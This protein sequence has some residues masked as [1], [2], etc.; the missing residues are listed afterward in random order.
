MRSLHSLF[1]T[2]V[3]AAS[4]LV[5]YPHDRCR[6]EAV[7]DAPFAQEYHEPQVL[8]DDPR[9][10]DVRSVAVDRSGK[11]WAATAAGVYR[12]SGDQEWS[13]MSPEGP[14]YAVASSPSHTVWAGTW[15]GIYHGRE[16]LTR[17]AGV[18]APIS[19][20]T[21]TGNRVYCF[22]PRGNWLI[23]TEG[24]TPFRVTPI[25]I[26][27]SKS[28]RAASIGPA[29]KLWLATQ[30]GIYRWDATRRSG[31]YWNRE[32]LP[33]ADVRDLLFAD[34]GRLWVGGLG[35]L[36]VFR[37]SSVDPSR[38]ADS[39]PSVD[40]RA[41]ASDPNGPI[42]VATSAGVSRLD[43]DGWSVRHSRRWLLSD[44]VRDIVCD[45]QGTAWIATSQGVSAI[46]RRQLTLAEKAQHFDRICQTR[47]VR[48]PGLVEK[49][50]LKTPG[51][52]TTW[53]P[54]DDD[55]DGQYTSMYLAME[56]FRYAATHDPVAKA[57][58]KRAF[59]ALR[60][61]QTVTQ[62]SGFVARTVIPSSW[63]RMHD[64]NQ[65][66][67]AQ[68]QAERM[69]GDPRDKYVPVRW[70]RSAD[71]Q[72]LWKGD[73]SSD[74]ITGHYYGYLMYYDL[75][76]DEAERRHVAQHVRKVTDYIIANGYVLQGMDGKPT[77]WGV[78]SPERLNHDPDWEMDRSTNSVELLSYL[79]AAYHMTG[80]AKYQQHYLL[81][82]REHGYAENARQ[83]KTMDPAWRTH[84]DDEL[85][86]LA[87]PALLL[88][89]TDPALRKIYRE[90]LD[91]WYAA[92]SVD[93]GPFFHLTYASLTGQ[94]VGSEETLRF[95]R[96]TPLDLVRWRVDNS[97][98]EDVQVTHF[99]EL[100]RDQTSRLLPID[101]ICFTRWD[102]NP[103]DTV[104][105]DGGHTESD[106]VF[107][108]LP[109]WMARYYDFLAGPH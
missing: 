29:G 42:W 41:V 62:T 78:W 40:I 59:E 97:H 82:I 35:G 96:D 76:A 67:T 72:W 44:D 80:D 13:L 50:H 45:D 101:E 73:T 52:L 30:M 19:V 4:L 34:D 89:E 20:I 90:S 88:K 38:S 86:A 74:E 93:R 51:D 75:V 68:Q 9:A 46:K 64:P 84:I 83:S 39:L 56:S 71:G 43:A 3:A 17:M 2:S 26:A 28:V 53:E 94:A 60:F 11:I 22:G 95:L 100:E 7:A 54:Y 108:L 18:N 85:L 24:G 37:G 49:C 104:Q 32:L 107:W 87:Y 61:L 57:N 10:G 6:A 16:Q 63:T 92:T 69:V 14:T 106:G 1:W 58:A 77:R 79:K 47:H 21:T 99:P 98:R 70:H 23:E 102:R 55:N 8:S 27:A 36:A 12:R 105:G 91:R 25:D 33:S 5:A 31:E 103:W 66:F 109:Y 15:N 48:P 65:T 81:L